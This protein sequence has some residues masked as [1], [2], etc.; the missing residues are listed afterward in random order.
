MLQP[1]CV[2]RGLKVSDGQEGPDE[3]GRDSPLLLGRLINGGPA[4]QTGRPLVVIP[5]D[6]D[7]SGN[8][9]TGIS[10]S[11]ECPERHMVATA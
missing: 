8:H 9:R 3:P 7:I 6:G 2:T 10:Q 11:V 5:D 1:T 4:Y